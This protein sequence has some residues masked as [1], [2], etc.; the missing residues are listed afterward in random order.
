MSLGKYQR[1]I[2]GVVVDVYD[3]LRAYGVTCPA[4]AHAVKKL[5]LPGQ[6]GAKSVME[7]LEEANRSIERAIELEGFHGPNIPQRK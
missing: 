3:I 1:E 2:N 7:D 5:L 6:R 4:V